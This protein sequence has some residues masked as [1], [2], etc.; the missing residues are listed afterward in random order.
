MCP[1]PPTSPRAPCPPPN[2]NPPQRL[3]GASLLVFA[4]KQ[5]IEGAL[6]SEE[7][8]EA[9]ELDAVSTRHWRIGACSAYTGK[10]LID[11]VDWIVRDIASRIF[12]YD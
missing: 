5:D 6:T 3:A 1:L 11:G 7:I 10:G 9:L 8:R 4:N 12:M 2:P